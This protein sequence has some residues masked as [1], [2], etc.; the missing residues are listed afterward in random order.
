MAITAEG[1]VV[2]AILTGGNTADISIGNALTSDIVGCYIVEDMGYDSDPH[3]A[4]IESNNN[5]PVIP[6]R[7]HRKIPII[8]DK[9]MYKLRKNI[10]IFFGKIK[11]NKRLSM[12]FE[13]ED[14][15]FLSIFAIAAIKIFL[16]IKIS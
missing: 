12:R 3:R 6:G 4:Y 2:A 7:K 1:H 10:E 16:N 15:V 8:Y 14:A 13:K 5:I 11:E 9:T